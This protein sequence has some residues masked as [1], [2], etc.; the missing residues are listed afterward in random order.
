MKIIGNLPDKLLRAFEKIEHADAFLSEGLMRFGTIAS[1]RRLEGLGRRDKTEGESH[2]VVVEPVKSVHF[3]PLS[4]KFLGTSEDIGEMNYKSSGPGEAYS[5]CTADVNVE[6][7]HLREK[8]GQFVVEI[9]NTK[10]FAES[11][12]R[13]LDRKLIVNRTLR[14]THSLQVQYSKG[15][16]GERPDLFNIQMAYGQKS[17]DFAADHEWRIV[18]VFFNYVGIVPEEIFLN[19]KESHSFA[20]KFIYT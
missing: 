5:F 11:I 12:E 8:F 16:I 17:P 13:E 2:V 19:L 9:H 4:Q 6:I 3:N 7:G 10:L 18:L 15:L 1:Y 20:R 14:S